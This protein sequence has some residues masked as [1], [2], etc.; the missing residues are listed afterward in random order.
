MILYSFKRIRCQ[1]SPNTV[2]LERFNT[3][4][5]IENH[6][7]DIRIHKELV[8]NEQ[9]NNKILILSALALTQSVGTVALIQNSIVQAYA[10]EK[11]KDVTSQQFLDYINE[12]KQ[13]YPNFKFEEHK[14]VCNSLQEAQQAE[15]NQKQQL[16]QSIKQYED[17]KKQSKDEYDAKINQYNQDLATYNQEKQAWETKKAELE[18][19]KTEEG[20]LTETLAQNLIF[21][22][23]PNAEVSVSGN[24]QG[25]WKRSDNRYG[26]DYGILD[27]KPE[28]GDI[29][30]IFKKVEEQ[31]KNDVPT[32]VESTGLISLIASGLSV[33]GITVLNK[34]KKA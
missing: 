24:F 16:E 15:Q 14:V 4:H 5:N 12:L 17:T 26:N 13:K 28:N 33:L 21:K 25:Y 1:E 7:T 22:D 34:K 11:N 19:K 29:V 3:T 27:Y 31:K 23:E 8:I 2:V 18:A 30:H 10:E 20:Q 9:K 32:G 6:K